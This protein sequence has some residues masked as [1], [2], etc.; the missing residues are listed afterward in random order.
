MCFVTFKKYFNC[1]ISEFNILNN[2]KY[3]LFQFLGKMSDDYGNWKLTQ[4]KL[5]LSKRGARLT[6]KKAALVERLRAYDR[7]QDFSTS[8]THILPEEIPMPAWPERVVFRTITPDVQSIFPPILEEHLSQY[9]INRQ[10]SDRQSINDVKAFK[11]GKLVA[12]NSVAALSWY[13]DLQF[14]FFCGTVNASMKKNLSYAVRIVLQ[15]TGEVQNSHCECPGG[16]GPHGT[17][18]HIVAILLV[19]S[20]FKLTGKLD[21]AKSC[22]ETLQ[23]FHHPNRSHAG[24]P[25]RCEKLG[26]RLD[27][28][29]DD[30]PRPVWL[31][32]RPEYSDQVMMK[33]INFSYHSGVDVA[34]RYLGAKA[35]LGTAALDHDYLDRDFRS[36]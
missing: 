15:Q 9:I 35:D 14:S 8:V 1:D 12:E 18:K 17:C 11:K 26:R 13:Q 29:A 6:G 32:N 22:T 24:S 33:V 10:G 36:H 19:C 16:V 28:E 27:Q 31:R 7:N 2:K 4:L 34:L 25:V 3:A 21:V 20:S 30:D 5:E 23:N